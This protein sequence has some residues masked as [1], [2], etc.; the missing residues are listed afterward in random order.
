VT[1]VV[2]DLSMLSIARFS[3]RHRLIALTVAVVVTVL[4]LGTGLVLSD[5]GD[6]A[7][8]DV[9]A[10]LVYVVGGSLGFTLVG[11]II[12]V[13]RPGHRIGRLM[14]AM[15]VSQAVSQAD[16]PIIG[17]LAPEWIRSGGIP[18]AI[19]SLG[20]TIGFLAIVL[21]G[22]L[23]IVWFP[24]GRTTSRLG[25]IVQAL[26]PVLLMG[27]FVSILDP[28]VFGVSELG[29]VLL[30]GTYVLALM[31]LLVR[32]RRSDG[33]R[34]T[35][36]RWVLASGSLTV[37]VVVA[38]MAFGDRIDWLW[39][40]WI[41]STIL[42]AV[43][44]GIAIT[45]YHLYDIDRIISRTIGYGLVTAVLFGVFLTAN[46]ALQGLLSAATRS[47]PLAV[48]GSTLLVAALFNPLRGRVQRVVDRR[49]NRAR[50]DAEHTVERFAG[51]L[52]DELDLS[53]LAGELQRTTSAAVQ[54]TTSAVWLRND[55][56]R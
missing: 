37:S 43:A 32:Y 6:I 55:A 18:E 8:W 46:L 5:I 53:T 2:E 52:R 3:A 1:P 30:A 13:Q 10:Q 42:P 15:G 24:D 27:Q 36:I 44:I 50:Y 23:L 28:T 11:A 39:Q 22:V 34:R 51:R 19:L 41:L 48:A 25:T 17:A 20:D 35:Q 54:P 14:M 33:A 7:P 45:R 9:L 21:G 31:D 29:F 12:L 26:V 49:F 40:L 38:V 47:D 16:A 56:V 4:A